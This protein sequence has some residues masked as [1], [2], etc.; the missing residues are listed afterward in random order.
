MNSTS[1]DPGSCVVVA[2]AVARTVHVPAALKVS[3]PDD[4]FTEQPVVPE[5]ITEYDIDPGPLDVANADGVAG[6]AVVNNDVVGF[7][8]T[9]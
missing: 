1:F 5:E 9:V 8:V 6:D 4:E 7:H 2:A 3:T